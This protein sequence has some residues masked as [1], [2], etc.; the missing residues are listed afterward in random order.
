MGTPGDDTGMSSI[1]WSCL[2][3]VIK[4]ISV[5]ATRSRE[6]NADSMSPQRTVWYKHVGTPG[7]GTTGPRSNTSRSC[8]LQEIKVR[9]ICDA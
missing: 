6:E 5:C 7:N 4:L 1:N 8:L 3:L 2:I 9:R